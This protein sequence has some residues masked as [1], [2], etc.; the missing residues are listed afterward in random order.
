MCGRASQDEIDDYFHRIYGWEIPEEFYS[1]RNLKPTER[2]YIVARHPEGDVKTVRA[3]W[4]CQWDGSRKF[5]A[6]FP[7][8]N[9]RVDTMDEKKLWPQMNCNGAGN[10]HQKESWQQQLI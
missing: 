3:N 4:W 6:K 2:A 10:I 8:F 1:R 5:E 7:T 9:I